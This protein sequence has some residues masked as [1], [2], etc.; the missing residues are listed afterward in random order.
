MF[1][2]RIKE[3]EEEEEE[4]KTSIMEKT[5]IL[6]KRLSIYSAPILP[7]KTLFYILDE[8]INNPYFTKNL[9]VTEVK[10]VNNILKNHAY[11]LEAI[12]DTVNEI[13]SQELVDVQHIPVII[14]KL[15]KLW[16]EKTNELNAKDVRISSLVMFTFESFIE[17]ELFPTNRLNRVLFKSVF[18]VSMEL[19]HTQLPT[20]A[21]A[22]V[23]EAEEVC[24]QCFKMTNK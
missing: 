15:A 14:L 8:D 11:F 23:E 12:Y 18:D 20:A 10:F 5:P 2:S 21:G 16:N 6:E 13:I 1:L 24:C 19:L 7:Y 3:D 17:A 22:A 4:T 9:T